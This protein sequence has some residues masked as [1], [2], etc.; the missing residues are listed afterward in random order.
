MT[1]VESNIPLEAHDILRNYAEG[2]H[3]TNDLMIGTANKVEHALA[4]VG[5]D[6]PGSGYSVAT[7]TRLHSR[8]TVSHFP[9][10]N[11][12]YLRK[13]DV[14]R[15]EVVD[16]TATVTGAPRELY[17]KEL[18]P[19]CDYDGDKLTD[20]IIRD[21]HRQR[22]SALVG[23]APEEIGNGYVRRLLDKPEI[24]DLLIRYYNEHEI[25]KFREHIA[26]NDYYKLGQHR[27]HETKN[28]ARHRQ[29]ATLGSYIARTFCPDDMPAI[30][31]AG[32]SESSLREERL[33]VRA[34]LIKHLPID[35]DAISD[36]SLTKVGLA[37]EDFRTYTLQARRR[38]KMAVAPQF[39]AL[40]SEAKMTERPYAGKVKGEPKSTARVITFAGADGEEKVGIFS[41][42]TDVS[43]QVKIS[44]GK[45]KNRH[46]RLADTELRIFAGREEAIRSQEHAVEKMNERIGIYSELH[47]KLCDYT[48]KGT[49]KSAFLSE[50][51]EKAKSQFIK[52]TGYH[53]QLILRYLVGSTEGK[54]TPSV[55]ENP[56]LIGVLR[57]ALTRA[58]A[59][60]KGKI[61]EVHL[62][63]KQI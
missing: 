2:P 46:H 28:R 43:T 24:C 31:S 63:K 19:L 3:Y 61:A 54:A 36:E 30:L 7:L 38:Y 52:K 22:L 59:D 39:L 14:F 57:K 25:T 33:A 17:K 9:D 51:V 16:K 44:E 5:V 60:T 21:T 58:I 53:D 11:F 45:E 4:S 13:P 55:L 40:L 41:T 20:K 8:D 10:S 56:S 12:K 1:K 15:R 50:L 62:L 35:P 37:P 47:N 18:G 23:K 48:K 49:E 32:R 29:P 27:L 26:G 42:V 34:D 6:F